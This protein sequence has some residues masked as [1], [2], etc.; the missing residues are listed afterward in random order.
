MDLKSLM[1]DT[2]N[3][4]VEFPGCDGFE[5]EVV[6]LARKELVALR[7]RC[8][9]TKFD[10]KTRQPIEELDDEKFVREFTK[11]TVKGWK[12]LKLKYLE[13]LILVDLK[14][15]DPES[16]LE[17]SEDNAAMLVENSSTFDGWLN[18][19]IFDLENFR[20]GPTGPAVETARKV[21]E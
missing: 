19:V 17:Y 6:N 20:S 4:W 9:T 15:V 7:K 5:V 11:A 16:F 3:A 13:D 21:A 8:V 10:R 14:K 12:G 1:V 2:K 18:D